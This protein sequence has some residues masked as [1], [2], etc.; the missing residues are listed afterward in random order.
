MAT[1]YKD[2]VKINPSKTQILQAL[3]N[4]NHLSIVKYA[5][6]SSK[7]TGHSKTQSF[8]KLRRH[9]SNVYFINSHSTEMLKKAAKYKIGKI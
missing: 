2:H 8:N 3:K 1:N 4:S 9:N 7:I 6:V 5:T